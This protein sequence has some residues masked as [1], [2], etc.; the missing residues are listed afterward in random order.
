[1]K[2]FMSSLGPSSEKMQ[3][4]SFKKNGKKPESKKKYEK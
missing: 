1:M 2:K 4:S 3:F